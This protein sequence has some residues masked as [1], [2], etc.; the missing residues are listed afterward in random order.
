MPPDTKPIKVV[1]KCIQL[2]CHPKD[3]LRATARYKIVLSTCVNAGMFY[4]LQ[5]RSDH[6]THVCIDES[7]QATE[8]ECLIP[9]GLC[10]NGQVR[11]VCYSAYFVH[12][13][14]ELLIIFLKKHCN[15]EMFGW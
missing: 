1:P 14:I 13:K 10:P 3:H 2:Y 5:L 6:F 8:P 7:G 4:T 9:I 12:K 11:C 15:L